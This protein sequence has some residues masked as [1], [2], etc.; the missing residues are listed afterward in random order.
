MTEFK[1]PWGKMLWVMT[2]LSFTALVLLPLALYYFPSRPVDPKPLALLIMPALFL[3]AALFSVRGYVLEPN[4]L[5]VKRLLWTTAVDCTGCKN[6]YHD[7]EATRGSIRTFG[8]GGLFAFTGR[9]R[10]KKLGS[11]R[12]YLTDHKRAVV[13][14]LAKRILVVSPHDPTAFIQAFKQFVPTA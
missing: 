8:N 9:F 13:L 11:Y 2:G 6:I 4:R 1:A 12:A 10:N 3:G 5:L 14:E 7:P